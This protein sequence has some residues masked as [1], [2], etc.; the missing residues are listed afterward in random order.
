MKREPDLLPVCESV[1]MFAAR[2]G[3]STSTVRRRIADGTLK[4]VKFGRLIRIVVE[5]AEH[6]G[7]SPVVDRG[8]KRVFTR[9]G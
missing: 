3:L 4:T 9:G 7:R 6:D 2:R 1:E 8:G 5:P